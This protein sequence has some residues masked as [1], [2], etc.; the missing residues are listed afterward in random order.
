MD[1]RGELLGRFNLRLAS[2]QCRITCV[3]WIAKFRSALLTSGKG[4]LG[5]K[6]A[7]VP[8]RLVRIEMQHGGICVGSSA[9]SSATMNGHVVQ[10]STAHSPAVSALRKFYK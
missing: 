4:Q 10:I 1:G 2:G 8:S 7:T 9:P 5:S 6:S 3:T